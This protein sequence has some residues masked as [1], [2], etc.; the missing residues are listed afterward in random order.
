MPGRRLHFLG[1]TGHS[2]SGR[3]LVV[4]NGWALVVG[5]DWALV[6]G[7]NW[8]LVVGKGWA[9]VVEKADRG[10]GVTTVEQELITLYVLTS[11]IYSI[12]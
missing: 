3:A 7:K 1:R 2:S 9:L 4:E 8:A 11:L 5:K 6:V 12:L 10:V